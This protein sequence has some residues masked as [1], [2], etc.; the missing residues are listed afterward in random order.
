VPSLN[1]SYSVLKKYGVEGVL[2]FRRCCC[3]ALVARGL[4][5]TGLVLTGRQESSMKEIL[6]QIALGMLMVNTF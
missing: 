3:K 1:G 4:P 6:P 2:R 5:V